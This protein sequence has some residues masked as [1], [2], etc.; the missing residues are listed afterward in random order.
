MPHRRGHGLDWL[1]TNPKRMETLTSEKQMNETTT[2]L[3][4]WLYEKASTVADVYVQ[5]WARGQKAYGRRPTEL[6]MQEV[7]MAF[8][9]GYI[10]GVQRYIHDKQL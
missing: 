8:Y 10:E 6:E 4:N 7:R 2:S 3:G 5:D 1:C 9:R